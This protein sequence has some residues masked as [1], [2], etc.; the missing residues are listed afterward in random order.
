[1]A[2]VLTFEGYLLRRLAVWENIAFAIGGICI[3]T[4]YT[5]TRGVAL[6]F[7]AFLLLNHAIRVR[8]ARLSEVSQFTDPDQTITKQNVTN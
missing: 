8:R 3:L 1:M 7:L 6:A 4:P 2:L 5:V